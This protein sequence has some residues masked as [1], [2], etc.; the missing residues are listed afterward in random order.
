MSSR[1]QNSVI[2]VVASSSLV[3]GVSHEFC[4]RVKNEIIPLM[5]AFEVP[6][7]AMSKSRVAKTPSKSV[8]RGSSFFMVAVRRT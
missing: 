4:M 3:K 1:W 2:F 5:I 8:M 7:N 6:N